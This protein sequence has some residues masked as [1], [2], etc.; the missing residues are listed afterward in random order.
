MR[1]RLGCAD[2]CPVPTT[3]GLSCGA[4]PRRYALTV[5]AVTCS[6][7]SIFTVGQVYIVEFRNSAGSPPAEWWWEAACAECCGHV[8][9]DM[10]C[11]GPGEVMNVRGLLYNNPD[12]TGGTTCLAKGFF[13]VDCSDLIDPALNVSMVFGTGGSSVCCHLG[14]SVTFALTQAP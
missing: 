4:L 3:C 11:G 13:T 5:T 12:P 8:I 7:P 2:D 10:A 14:E 6:G 9:L 1:F